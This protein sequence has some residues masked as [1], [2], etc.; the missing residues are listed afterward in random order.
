[1]VDKNMTKEERLQ[2]IWAIIRNV[3][4]SWILWQ[5]RRFCMNIFR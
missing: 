5:I 4:D 2:A 3:D 1:M